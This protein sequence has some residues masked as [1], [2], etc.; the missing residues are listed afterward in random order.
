M[1]IDLGQPGSG[2]G[3]DWPS[4]PPEMGL[5]CRKYRKN[6]GYVINIQRLK[7]QDEKNIVFSI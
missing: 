7:P 1:Q 3:T 6:D 5:N 4:F 2:L